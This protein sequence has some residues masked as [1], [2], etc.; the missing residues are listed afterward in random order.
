MEYNSPLVK[1]NRLQIFKGVKRSV[2]FSMGQNVS[3]KP[4][5]KRRGNDDKKV[6]R[7][8]SFLGIGRT[9]VPMTR[10]DPFQLDNHVQLEHITH[11]SKST[12]VLRSHS[13]GGGLVMKAH[14]DMQH[15]PSGAPVLGETFRA[16]GHWSL[17]KNTSTSKSS[18]GISFRKSPKMPKVPRPNRTLLMFESV[19]NGI[20]EFIQATREDIEAL[21][22]R[23]VDQTT[24]SQ[25]IKAA[26]RYMKRLEF[27]LAKIEELHD[28]YRVQQQMREGTRTMQRAFIVSP[29]RKKDSME[30]VRYG[31]KECSQT[32][33]SIEA[34]LEAMMGTFSCKLKGMAGFARLCPGDVFEIVIKHGT[35]KWKSKGRIEKNGTQKWDNPDFKF[36]AVIG[37]VFNIKGI[38]LRLLKSVTLGQKK[39]ETKDLFS[40]NPQLMTVS[41]NTNGSLKLSVIIIWN[42]LDGVE[43]TMPYFDVPLRQPSAPRRRPVSVMALNGELTQSDFL[44]PE[45]RYSNPVSLT[46]TKDDNFILR[47][48]APPTAHTSPN[49]YG[50]HLSSQSNV[51]YLPGA[52]PQFM[53]THSPPV[54]SKLVAPRQQIPQRYT[55]SQPNLN[56]GLG[57]SPTPSRIPQFLSSGSH[58]TYG[59]MHF[60]VAMGHGIT[61]TKDEPIHI[62]DALNSLS[63]S[64]EDYHG[65][66]REL[67]KLEDVVV[68]LE[69]VLRKESRC[70]SRTGSICVSVQDALGAFDFLD[71][72]VTEEGETSQESTIFDNVMSSPESTAKTADS[73]IES[74]AKRLSEDTNLGSS[75]GSSPLPP[76]TGNEHVDQALVFHLVYCE[77]LLE[78]LGSF[79]PLKCREIYALDRLQ[80][81][82]EI[83]EHLIKISQSSD[84]NLHAIMAEL[85]DDK[86][87]R[88]FWVRCT[89]TNVLYIHPE[90][91]VGAFEQKYGAQLQ[92]KYSRDP[93]KVLRH[94]VMR[95]LDVPSYDP[96]KVKATCIVTLHQFL[97]YFKDEGGLQNVDA[98]AAELQMIEKLCSGKTES[99]IKCVMSLKGSFPPAPCLKVMGAL[100]ISGS[101]EVARTVESYLEDIAKTKEFRDKA[102]LV[103]V[104]GLEDKTPEIRA[105]ACEAL[106]KL[107]AS[108]SIAQLSY[109][110]Q[111]DTSTVVR[112][113][114]KQALFSFGEV[115]RH[116]FEEIQ[117]S[118]HG[119]QGLQVRK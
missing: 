58:D 72:E 96:E 44:G 41:I 117:L 56:S 114:S 42:P 6:S 99:I 52:S 30:R 22:S 9:K 19:K 12:P 82:A 24:T 69:Q 16:R 105:G 53:N 14:H 119:F 83:I 57:T 89:D 67:E 86:S 64:L 87:L 47:T 39:C 80:K 101:N 74:L 50:N 65:Q 108:E 20:R 113:R 8:A 43:E 1:Q 37:D 60:N 25:Q 77:R 61:L 27:H 79:G 110:C 4:V 116:A 103:F 97:Q 98:V 3:N 75:E 28:H 23:T 31:L 55:V 88:E 7:H 104:E 78:S 71:T 63:A 51:L 45:R 15:T 111:T 68:M 92:S 66:Y 93:K 32:M 5:V 10:K 18:P 106:G 35:Q 95:I 54:T 102:L 38:E 33:C 13:F 11:I 100:L 115:G 46:Q 29:H 90:K 36:K 2:T 62:E 84:I 94:L 73:G 85:S 26:E 112:V 48:S 40:A 107:E 76:S 81:Q 70:S 21:H 34:Q 49:H 17:H 118:T 59:N 109:L 91:L